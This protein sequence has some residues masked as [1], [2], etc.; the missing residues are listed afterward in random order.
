MVNFITG[1]EN[2]KT[3]KTLLR[4][5]N[6]LKCAVAFWGDEA[7][8]LLENANTKVKIICNLESG[9][10]NPYVISKL[11]DNGNIDIKT[12]K[13]LHAKVYWSPTTAIVGSTNVSS[14]GLGLEGEELTG[15]IEASILIKEDDINKAIETWFDNLFINSDK[16][17]DIVLSNAKVAWSERRKI[18]PIK[19]VKIAENNESE[20][21]PV[22]SNL[23]NT[24]NATFSKYIL[25]FLEICPHTVKELH[26]KVKSRDPVFY[27]EVNRLHLEGNHSSCKHRLNAAIQSLKERDIVIPSGN[28]EGSH[29]IWKLKSH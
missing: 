12:H 7:L 9:A 8:N 10:T 15:W 11:L 28:Y 27:E 20:S 5:E 29:I 25:E 3:I 1:D 13:Q 23:K 16:I 19:L 4:E 22:L 2:K 26:A 17:D 24:I 18:R 6:N 21:D 14:N